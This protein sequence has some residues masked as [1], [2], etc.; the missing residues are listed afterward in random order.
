MWTRKRSVVTVKKISAAVLANEERRILGEL[1]KRRLSAFCEY[2][3]EGAWKHA[4]H[5][6]ILCEKIEEAERWINEKH[7]EFKLIMVCI[8]MRHG[9]SEVVSRHAPAWFLGR[10]PDKE[11]IQASHT[12]SLATDM[13]RDARRIFIEY[14]CPLFDLELSKETSSVELWHVAGHKGKMQAAG[15]NGPLMGKGAHFAVVDDPHKSLEEAESPTFQRKTLQWIKSTLISRM[16]PGGALVLVMSRLHVKDAVGQLKEEAK[17]SGIVW[18]IVKFSATA[19]EEV[20][21]EGKGTGRPVKDGIGR[22]KIGDPLWPWR[23][24]K[25]QLAQ[26][27]AFLANERIWFAQYE[28]N[29]TAD[30]A[31]ALWKLGLIQALRMAEA[32]QLYRIIISWDPAMTSERTSDEHGIFVQAIGDAYYPAGE[33]PRV[34]LADD[35]HGYVLEDLSDIYTP[36]EACEIVIEAYENWGATCVVA[37]INQGGDTVESLLRTRDPTGIIVYKGISAIESKRGRAEPVS[38]LYTQRRIHHIGNFPELETEQTTW[39]GPPMPSPSRL[40]AV[41]HGFSFL[42]E[43]AKK[44]R[45][46]TKY[47]AITYMG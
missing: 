45:K 32:P 17:V 2:A 47:K 18:E 25:K 1:A 41:V 34:I 38:A 33:K 5:L 42:F 24:N 26:I 15:V 4:K 46:R 7:D 19:Q 3:G 30:V 6:D 40:D 23:F 27:R 11:V 36:D 28:Q 9:K 44:A 35:K 31:G 29:P 22:K 20:D 16:A 14:A 12:A 37:E 43:L 39:T 21:A 13:S 8:P 10:N